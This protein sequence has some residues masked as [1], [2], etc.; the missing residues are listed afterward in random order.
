[1][2]AAFTTRLVSGL[3]ALI[4]ALTTGQ[5]ILA[6]GGSSGRTLRTLQNTTVPVRDAPDLAARLSGLADATSIQ[7]NRAPDYR[8]GDRETFFVGNNDSNE[9]LTV[10]ATLAAEAPGVYLWVQDGIS[11]DPARLAMVASFLDQQLFPAVRELFG[12]EASPGIDGDPHIYVLNVQNIGNSIG[13]YFNDSSTYP[14]QIFETSNEHEMFVVAVD[15]VPFDS[16]AYPYVLAHEFVH[17]IQHNIDENEETWVTEGTAELGAF[18]T[19][20][21][22]LGAINDYLRNPTIQLNSWDIDN[23]LPYYGAAALFFNYLSE[24]LG[25]AF[26]LTHSQQPADS[27]DGIDQALA[28]LDARDPVSGNLLTFNDLFAD[29]LIANLLNDSTLADGRFGYSR[30]RLGASPAAITQTIN[31]YPIELNYQQVNQF[32]ARYIRLESSV[33]R[34]VTINFTGSDTV[35]V[36][37]TKAHSGQHVYWANRTDQSNPRLTRA[38]D[39]SD[40]TSATFSFWTWYEMEPFWDYG[41]LS[42]STDGGAS[43]IPLETEATTHQDPNNRAFAAGYTGFSVGG[44]EMRPAPYLGVR[45]NPENGAIIGFVPNSNAEE[46]GLQPGDQLLAVDAMTLDDPANLITLLNRYQANDT[47]LF[48]VLRDG[49]SVDVPVTLG[50]HPAR[51]VRPAADWLLQTVDLTPYTGQRVLIRFE[52]VTD[53]AFTRNG[54]V[55]DDISIPE[56][57]FF[58]DMEQLDGWQAEGWARITNELPQMFLVQAVSG[59]TI[60]RW[61]TPE[62]DVTGSWELE[63]GPDNPATLIISG[64]TRYTTQPAVYNLQITPTK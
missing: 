41:Y 30:L 29:W 34:T 40:V 23:P 56:I 53:Q 9:I 27:I 24:R 50:E 15:N 21:A 32:G 7:A 26:S 51:T 64:Q 31:T 19:V 17:M 49:K 28:A 6:Q 61:L 16:S 60:H 3:L 43:W 35:A 20:G 58:D 25:P 42:I 37:P 54:W 5:I 2:R 12:H 59:N 18:L 48:T 45:F 22:R 63:I 57:G 1:M 8:T 55:L 47:V 39:L 10:E 36:V 38:F 46:A 14:R 11:Y 13:G 52:Y 33:P 44:V 4:F 62:D